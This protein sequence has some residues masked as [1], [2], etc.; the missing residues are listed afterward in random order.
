MDFL[1][2]EVADTTRT[3]TSRC[4]E[5]FLHVPTDPSRPPSQG[6]PSYEEP[7]LVGDSQPWLEPSSR[8]SNELKVIDD[9]LKDQSFIN[10]PPFEDSLDIDQLIQS[11]DDNTTFDVDSFLNSS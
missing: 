6:V 5:L 4:S 11:V 3:D 8:I 1:Y 9:L 7:G 10:S 2:G